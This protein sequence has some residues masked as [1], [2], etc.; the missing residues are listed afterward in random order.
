MTAGIKTLELLKQ[1]GT[2]EK[3]TATTQ[4]LVAVSFS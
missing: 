2:Y 4:K 3:L 1:P